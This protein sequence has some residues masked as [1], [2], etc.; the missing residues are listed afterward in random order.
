MINNFDSIIISSRIRLAR[1]ISGYNF[2]VK[3]SH[4]D[5]LQVIGKVFDVL[6]KYENYKV[7]DL[8]ST[9]LASLKEKHLI[10]QNLIDN[11]E[12]GAIC[13]SNDEQICIM[14]NEE[15][16]LRLQCLLKGYNLDEALLKLNEVDDVLLENLPISYSEDYGFISTCPSNLGTGMRASV[17]LF[18][19]ALCLLG[20]IENV[21]KTLSKLGL[22]VRGYFG[23]GS[24]AEGFMFQVSNNQTLGLT[25]AQIIENVKLTVEKICEKELNARQLLLNSK[26]EQL[27]DTIKRAYG[28]LKYCYQIDYTEA[29]KLL[30]QIKLGICLNLIDYV[31]LDTIDKLLEDIMPNTLLNIKGEN[32]TD[33]QLNVFRA[34]YISKNI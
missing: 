32:L 34:E 4:Q 6:P 21:I 27:M 31:T 22:T 18:L 23:E 1:N 7:V 17:M 9:I 25:E 30:S 29:T 19:P 20:M 3:L 26:K 33:N 28:V 8:D 5:A 12:N 24:N 13:L 11:K 2:P 16:H 10:S 14:I 15:E